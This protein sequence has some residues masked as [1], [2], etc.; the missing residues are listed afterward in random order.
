M[1]SYSSGKKAG[2]APVIVH[3]VPLNDRNQRTECVPKVD[4]HFASPPFAL[5]SRSRVLPL[6]VGSAQLL[7]SS[8]LRSTSLSRTKGRPYFFASCVVP[9]G[10]MAIARPRCMASQALRWVSSIQHYSLSIQ[11]Y[12]L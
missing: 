4:E 8:Q 10:R 6:S 5:K 3:L 9:F 12:S 11:H 2:T 1:F 7:L